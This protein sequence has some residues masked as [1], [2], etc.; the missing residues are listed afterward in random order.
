MIVGCSCKKEPSNNDG[1]VQPESLV[2]YRRKLKLENAALVI[3]Q[4]KGC[5]GDGDTKQV[6]GFISKQEITHPW[7]L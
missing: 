3:S 4:V 7:L 6:A 2:G 5:D 1:R